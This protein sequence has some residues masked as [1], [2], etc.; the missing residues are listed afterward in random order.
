[1]YIILAAIEYMCNVHWIKC[2][3]GTIELLRV[4]RTCGAQYSLDSR[5]THTQTQSMYLFIY[6]Y[7]MLY[8]NYLV[9]K[10]KDELMP[11][12]LTN[13]LGTCATDTHALANHKID[14]RI[15][16]VCVCVH[17]KWHSFQ[18]KY[19]NC[20]L[21]NNMPSGLRE[22]GSKYSHIFRMPLLVVVVM[23]V[24]LQSGN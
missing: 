23:V 16:C 1:M 11:N 8:S 14:C 21:F 6:S 19:N 9:F 12:Y 4:P 7:K 15:V 18:R 24:L 2:S 20:L 22:N 17:P 13:K 5:C 10:L 3:C